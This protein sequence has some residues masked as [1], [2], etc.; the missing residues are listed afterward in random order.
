MLNTNPEA[1][2]PEPDEAVADLTSQEDTESVIAVDLMSSA[3]D[4]CPKGPKPALLFGLR[5]LLVLTPGG[6]D[7][8]GKETYFVLS[9]YMTFN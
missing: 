3:P 4:F 7:I 6:D 8:L 1:G 5:E 2:S 9:Y